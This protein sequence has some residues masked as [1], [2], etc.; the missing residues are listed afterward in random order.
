MGSLMGTTVSASATQ[1][2]TVD[3][4]NVMRGTAKEGGNKRKRT[5]MEDSSE[6][7]GERVTE[8]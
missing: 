5:D 2:N 8:Q 1:E 6:D 4:G 3:D 7:I